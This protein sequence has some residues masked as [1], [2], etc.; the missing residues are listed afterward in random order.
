MAVLQ[1]SGTACV[2]KLPN[3]GCQCISPNTHN[4]PS[5]SAPFRGSPPH[6]DNE[7]ATKAAEHGE[8]R[9]DGVDAV[10]PG[11]LARGGGAAN[12]LNTGRNSQSKCG[13]RR[14]ARLSSRGAQ[15]TAQST[16]AAGLG[17][18]RTA[19]AARRGRYTYRTVSPHRLRGCWPR[20]AAPAHLRNLRHSQQPQRSDLLNATS[21]WLGLTSSARLS[22]ALGRA[23]VGV[24]PPGARQ[25]QRHSSPPPPALSPHRSPP[26][27]HPPTPGPLG[28][29][30]PYSTAAG[31][32]AARR[33]LLPPEHG[34]GGPVCQLCL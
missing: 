26:A 10:D 15:G 24:K 18:L 8:Q 9:G 16:G 6:K 20:G 28:L 32:E 7:Q 29:L 4:L 30:R 25:T 5:P 1:Q 2:C 34:L 23:H 22:A 19:S 31:A 11:D 21:Q 14:N 27:P 3:T 12:R 17:V 33:A 13:A